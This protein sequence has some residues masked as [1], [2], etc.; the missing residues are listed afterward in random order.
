MRSPLPCLWLALALVVPTLAPAREL[1]RKDR[2]AVL[3]S[4]QVTFDRKGEP[5]VSVRVT[6]GQ[7]ELR[8]RTTGSLTLLPGA[9]DGSRLVPPKGSDWTITLRDGRPG[10]V[11]WWV[12]AERLAAGDLAQAAARRAHWQAQGHTVTFFESGALIG[13]AGETL[14]TRQLTLAIAPQPTQAAAEAQAAALPGVL[15]EVVDE[16]LERPGGWIIARERK[17]QVEL[18]AR[19]LLWISPEDD[20][21]IEL[22]DMEWGHGTPKRGRQTRRYQG[23][24]YVAVGN[25][26]KLA[27]VNVL[28]A[29]RLL[30]GVVPSELYVSAPLEA[31]KAQAVA[32][33]GQLLAKVGTRHRADPYLLCAETHCQVYSGDTKRHPKTDQ[34]VRETR[35]RLLFH[36]HGLIDT[37]YSSACGGHSE[38]FHS[39]WGGSP[40]P[41]LGGRFDRDGGEATPIADP[42]AFIASTPKSW[43]GFKTGL[44][45]WTKRLKGADVSQAINA[46]KPIGPVT[47]IRATRRGVSGRALAVEYTGPKGT[48]VV[49]GAYN[50]RKLLGR[51][52]SGLWVVQREG[53]AP[54]GE[55][56][57]WVF[58]GGGFGHGVGMCQH[59]AI[60]QADAGRTVDQI[61]SHYY[62]GSRLRRA[63]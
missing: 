18:R 14:D 47:G 23:D 63:W 60:A 59:G 25:D 21:P 50:N 46:R 32:A 33:R 53:G 35:G 17:T 12:V 57:R 58:Q 42:A 62:P 45:R 61:L 6:E 55:P 38:A 8:L 31:L 39:Y 5:L 24:L 43:C 36:E 2:L 22:P 44:F 15:G 56:A 13:L 41:G 7:D 11:Q 3:Y 51:L 20:T 1:S 30:A 49:E 34:A 27:A 48:L 37:V 40:K 10:K 4:N 19:D 52:R 29:E 28:S 26:G 16:S 9:D 54:D